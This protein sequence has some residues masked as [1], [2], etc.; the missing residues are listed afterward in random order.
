MNWQGDRQGPTG[1]AS[2]AMPVLRVGP[3]LL[4]RTTTDPTQHL[5]LDELVCRN[6]FDAVAA[7][8]AFVSYS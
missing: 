4:Q 2:I 6:P 1:S 3:K 7:A 5:S 8:F